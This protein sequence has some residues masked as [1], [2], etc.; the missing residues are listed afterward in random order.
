MLFLFLQFS[1]FDNWV[2]P[3]DTR[4]SFQGR[5]KSTTSRLYSKQIEVEEVKHGLGLME[6]T[7]LAVNAVG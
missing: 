7:S 4:V 2:S 1:A 5:P 3:L 6:A